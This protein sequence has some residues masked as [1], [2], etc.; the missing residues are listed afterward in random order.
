MRGGLAVG[1]RQ[2]TLVFRHQGAIAVVIKL[3][4]LRMVSQWIELAAQRL[5][6]S[7]G[8]ALVA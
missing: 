6:V 2:L 5:V 8:A 3:F 1:V 7:E 4:L